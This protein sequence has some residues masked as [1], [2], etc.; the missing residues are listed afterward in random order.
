MII[1]HDVFVC[2]PG[3]ASKAAK[4]FKEAMASDPHLLYVLTDVAGQFHRAIMVSQYES[5]ADWEQEQERW[6]N[7]TPEMQE[8]IKKMGDF[9]SMYDSGSREIYRS[10]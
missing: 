3:N 10:W 5:L 9:Q 6:S 4:M 2:K 7:P 1:I 8:T